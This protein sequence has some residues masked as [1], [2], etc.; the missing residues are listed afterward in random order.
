MPVSILCRLSVSAHIHASL[1][2]HPLLSILLCG[3]CPGGTFSFSPCLQHPPLSRSSTLVTSLHHLSSDLPLRSS[4]LQCYSWWP[5][6]GCYQLVLASFTILC[7]GVEVRAVTSLVARRT[8]AHSW[9]T[10]WHLGRCPNPFFLF[11][12]WLYKRHCSWGFGVSSDSPHLI[13][14]L[15]DLKTQPARK[16]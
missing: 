7:V 15:R 8:E 10:W 12:V 13:F 5:L 1:P 2:S 16:A 11:T 14:K 6:C 9:L 4:H 3:P